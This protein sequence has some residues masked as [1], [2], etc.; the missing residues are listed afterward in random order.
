MAKLVS[1]TYGEALFDLAKEEGKL[2]V[3]S[4][5]VQFVS[6]SLN[7]N[8]DL[9]RLLNHPKIT[10]E[11]KIK[12]VESIFKGRLSDTTTGFLVLVVQKGRSGELPEILSY[13]IKKVKEYKNIGVASIT[14]ATALSEKQKAEMEKKLLEITSYVSFET[15]YDVDESLIGGVV[16]RIGDRVVDSSIRTKLDNMA[17][18][19][20]NS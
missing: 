17:K 5:E 13:F 3:I 7:E 4:E 1:K 16:I 14:S 12:V 20:I 15:R 19:L 10:V 9:M 6:D 8:K 18:A 11:E 2:D